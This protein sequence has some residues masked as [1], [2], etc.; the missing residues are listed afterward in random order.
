MAAGTPRPVRALTFDLWD[1]LVIDDSDEPRRAARGLPP[2]V[3]ARA[4]GFVELVAPKGIPEAEARAA[5]DAATAQ[6]KIWWKQEHH[7]PPVGVRVD[8]ALS[9]LGLTRP[10]GFDELV[11]RL[12]TM[13][14]E[15]PPDPLPGAGA[16]L[17]ALAARYPL[18]IISDSIVTP[19][20]GLRQILEGHGLARH[21][22]AFF[23][24]DEVGASKPDPKPY[25]AAAAA[26]DIPVE[27]I[28]HVGDRDET[29]IAGAHAVGARGVYFTGAIDRGPTS[30]PYVCAHLTEL[31]ALCAQMEG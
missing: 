20:A 24:S 7:T 30:S 9:A 22:S 26:L 27:G 8:H 14:V 3:E 2:K 13:E 10:A 1:T 29:D 17:A 21:F 4:R 31:P 12:S 16:A 11:T 5:W 25:P 23:F 28:V 18:A 19:A 6:F 15:I